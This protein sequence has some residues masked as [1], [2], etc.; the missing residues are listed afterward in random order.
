MSQYLLAYL[1]GLVTILSPC[2]LPMLPIVLGGALQTHRH[3]PLALAAGLVI[4]F[5]GFGMLIATIG[6]SIGLTPALFSKITAS[7]MIIF[8][9]ILLSTALQ[10]RFALATQSTVSGLNNTVAAFSPQT[11]SGQFWLGGLLGAVWTPCIG[12]TLGAAIALAAQGKDLTHAFMIMLSFAIGTVT[13]LIGL[14]YGTKEMVA[15]RK[16]AM[17]ATATW[18]KPL[19]GGLL[20]TVGLLLITGWM[21]KWEAYLLEISPPWLISFIYS[22]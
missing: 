21:T 22:F 18:M 10:S 3:G 12:P 1:A 5:T 2:V 17:A 13:P 8:G 15:K 14:M 9:I 20:L 6:F 4:S 16:T 19:L 7:L 11:L